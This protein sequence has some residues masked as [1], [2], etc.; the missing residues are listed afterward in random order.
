MLVHKYFWK[1]MMRAECQ[2]SCTFSRLLQVQPNGSIPEM[3]D[4][5]EWPFKEGVWSIQARLNCH[6]SIK[7]TF[8]VKTQ[9]SEL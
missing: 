4:P 9:E 5:L 1:T 3:D 2:L 7:S 8:L 6:V